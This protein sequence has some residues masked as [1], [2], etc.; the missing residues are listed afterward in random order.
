MTNSLPHGSAG[1]PPIPSYSTAPGTGRSTPGRNSYAS[2]VSGVAQSYTPP[3]RS[4]GSPWATNTTT[5]TY[6]HY[7]SSRTH[8]RHP[9]R[10]IDIGTHG[11]ET[12]GLIGSLSRAGHMG[13]HNTSPSLEALTRAMGAGNREALPTFLTPSYLRGSRYLQELQGSYRASLKAHQDS[14][15]HGTPVG[16]LSAS[17][18]SVNLHKTSGSHKGLAHDIVERAPPFQLDENMP[19]LPSRWS[20]TDKDSG[21]EVT[22]DGLSV[23]FTG[24]SK[25]SDEAAS[26]RAEHHM[27]PECGIYYYE[28]AISSRA[29]EALIAVGF[30]AKK[31]SL[32]RLPGWEEQSWAYHSDDGYSFCCTP[33]GKDYGPK[34]ASGDVIG[35]GVNFRTGSAFFTKNGINLG[36]AFKDIRSDKL[37]PSIG[38]KKTHESVHAN[39]GDKPF[40][41]DIDGLMRSEKLL[42]QAEINQAEAS[43]LHKRL[44]EKSLIQDLVAQYLAH[45][46][47]VETVRAFAQEVHSESA[48]LNIGTNGGMRSVIEPQED[49]DAIRRQQIRAAVLEGDIDKAIEFTSTHY[50]AVLTLN[51]NIYFKLRCQKYVEMIRRCNE[52]SQS[53]SIPQ[54][55]SSNGLTRKAKG[56]GKDILPQEMDVDGRDIM[57][58]EGVGDIDS[59]T[60]HIA[61]MQE[62][63]RYGQELRGE[64][65]NDPRREVKKAL[66]ETIAL[67]AYHEPMQSPLAGLLVDSARVPIAEELNGAILVSL[68]KNSSSALERLYKQSEALL[69]ELGSNGGSGAFVNIKEDI[70]GKQES[71]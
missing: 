16:S 61:L 28:V 69:R 13:S 48:M 44:D 49:M 63:L 3:S 12:Q 7:N 19:P 57:D 25:T 54:K 24:P 9:S 15:S 53:L 39:F 65:S 2:V 21:L 56:K 64:F 55:P 40:V 51:E 71:R 47:Y 60:K 14:R 6:P 59:G 45:D 32:H 10:G 70:L 11:L 62:T 8:S 66:E 68:G 27:P 34:F 41:F 23:R 31:V 22:N 1:V 37:Y 43:S 33:S 38:M 67:I 36:T 26:I 29:K 18:S 50:P 17:S 58:D 42:I 46:G 52:L 30:S 5:P 20:D 4:G 35:C